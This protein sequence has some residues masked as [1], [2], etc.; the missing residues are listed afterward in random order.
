[1]EQTIM[2]RHGRPALVC[3]ALFGLGFGGPA[4]GSQLPPGFVYLSEV[5]PDILQDMRYAGPDNFTGRRVPDYNAPQ[6]VLLREVA[7]ALG[8]VQAELRAVAGT[9]GV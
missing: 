6:C 3:A 5:A 7:E 4:V 2:S 8:R 9:E 1:V